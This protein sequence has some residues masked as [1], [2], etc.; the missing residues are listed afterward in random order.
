MEITGRIIAVLPERSGMSS[1]TGTEW[2][3]GSYVLETMD[4]YPRKMNFE[5]F[6]TDRIQ[7]FNI[8]TGEILTVSFDIDAHEYNGRWFNSIRA[9]KVD[10]NVQP[11]VAAPGVAPAQPI[12]P[13]PS[14]PL[15]NE[16]PAAAPSFS[17]NEGEDLPF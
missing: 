2:K 3:V 7:Q 9:F 13:M 10:R 1:R 5:V 14:A 11:A 8:Q 6:G 12:Q 16:A 17:S 15:P 4:Q